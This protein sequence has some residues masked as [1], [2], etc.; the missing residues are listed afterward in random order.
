[1]S[2]KF[3]P[4]ETPPGALKGV[5]RQLGGWLDKTMAGKFRA[6]GGAPDLTNEFLA[7][8]SGADSSTPPSFELRETFR[9][10]TLR[11]GQ[12]EKGLKEGS[13]LTQ[14]AEPTG[15]WHHQVMCNGQPVGFA[16]SLSESAEG[17]DV[18][19]LYVSALARRID[20]AVTWIDDFEQSNPDYAASDPVVR[21]LFI[22]SYQTHAFWIVRGSSGGSLRALASR[23]LKSV[24]LNVMR[25][26]GGS[27]VLIIDAPSYL[28][29][30]PPDQKPLRGETLLSSKELLEAFHG[31]E[32]LGGGLTFGSSMPPPGT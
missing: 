29:D 8:G 17:F 5:S 3:H 1:M 13:D 31:K 23:V 11:F 27:D 4:D 9:V 26:S 19:Q 6:A 25:E 15:R 14:L 22:P 18:C 2:K 16:R 7:L 21:L 12:I 20:K 32:P 28:T 30:V 24:G 10:Y